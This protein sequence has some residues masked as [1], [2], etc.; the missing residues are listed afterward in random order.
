[1]T[2]R[3]GSSIVGSQ[4]LVTNG[5]RQQEYLE[6]DTNLEVRSSPP[7]I[8]FLW[9]VS[10]PLDAPTQN[11][12]ILS[13]SVWSGGVLLWVPNVFLGE[14]RFYNLFVDWNLAGVNWF[15]KF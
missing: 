15:V 13:G 1:M 11:K 10:A 2:E 9:L 5:V 4:T 3:S 7:K 8:G 14:K 6:L 12:V